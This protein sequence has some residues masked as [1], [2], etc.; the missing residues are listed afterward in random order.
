LVPDRTHVR[1]DRTVDAPERRLVLLRH[2]KSDR[3]PGMPD[4]VRPLSARGRRDAAAVGRWLDDQRLRPDLVLCS[5]A[6]RA[7]QTWEEAH[8]ELGGDVPTRAEPRLYDTSA[9]AV[10]H[11]VAEVP[12]DVR[13]LLVVAHEPTMSQVADVLAGP[14]SDGALLAQVRAHLP[15]SG[16]VV[17]TTSGGWSQVE[18]GCCALTGL[19]APR[20]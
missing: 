6:T 1:E 5:D 12:D 4:H 20:G 7:L 14:D 17:L 9:A 18:A 13:T 11:L 10:V 8:A 16:V 2:A 19:A 15:T 3:P